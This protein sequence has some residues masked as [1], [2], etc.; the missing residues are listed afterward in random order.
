MGT[1]GFFINDKMNPVDLDRC[2]LAIAK[3]GG[4]PDHGGIIKL[5]RM[6]EKW[7]M[8]HEERRRRTAVKH[9]I[10]EVALLEAKKTNVEVREEELFLRAFF[11]RLSADLDGERILVAQDLVEPRKAVLDFFPDDKREKAVRRFWNLSAQALDEIK[12]AMRRTY[13]AM[14]AVA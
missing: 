2:G 1:Q 7:E 11:D 5:G 3:H 13:V 10:R 12:A 14:T 9:A 8:L 6:A 4:R